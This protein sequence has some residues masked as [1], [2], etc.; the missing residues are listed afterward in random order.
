MAKGFDYKKG[1]TR[2]RRQTESRKFRNKIE[3]KKDKKTAILME[4]VRESAERGYAQCPEH[5]Y[6]IKRVGE[7]GAFLGC[8]RF[9]KC[10]VTKPLSG[11]E[12]TSPQAVAQL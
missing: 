1:G 4:K 11:G 2:Y 12:T 3:K 10:R 8:P 6:L 5:G 7:Y 9:P